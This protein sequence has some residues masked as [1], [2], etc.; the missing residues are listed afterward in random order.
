MSFSQIPPE[1]VGQIQAQAIHYT[2]N[3]KPRILGWFSR[4]TP[5]SFEIIGHSTQ[6]YNSIAWAAGDTTAWWWPLPPDAA[7]WPDGIPNELTVEAFVQ[8][9]ATLGYGP[10][11][12]AH[13]DRRCFIAR[14]G[15]TV[16][17]RIASMGVGPTWT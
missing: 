1:I 10:C 8:A 5:G 2:T 14:A 7:F 16:A 15:T 3:P 17:D 6:E 12:T 13:F 9:F 11:D 4:L